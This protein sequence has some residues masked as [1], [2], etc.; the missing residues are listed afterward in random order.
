MRWSQLDVARDRALKATASAANKSLIAFLGV[1]RAQVFVMEIFVAFKLQDLGHTAWASL[2]LCFALLPGALLCISFVQK[3]RRQA[4][5]LAAL[6]LG[7][8]S[9]CWESW[10]IADFTKEFV[11][12]SD[13]STVF[14]SLP[15][16]MLQS[17]LM[18]HNHFIGQQCEEAFDKTC[19][20][21]C[22]LLPRKFGKYFTRFDCE[23]LPASGG[24]GTP[25]QKKIEPQECWEWYTYCIDACAATEYLR[26][27]QQAEDAFAKLLRNSGSWNMQDFLA[28]R[29]WRKKAKADFQEVME[30]DSNS[31][32][33]AGCD[34]QASTYEFLFPDVP[35]DTPVN[36]ARSMA[37]SLNFQV[38]L[39]YSQMLSLAS[40]A[41]SLAGT[42]TLRVVQADKRIC[43]GSRRE[44]VAEALGFYVHYLLDICSTAGSLT[45]FVCGTSS[46]MRSGMFLGIALISVVRFNQ[47]PAFKKLVWYKRAGC[48][49][50]HCVISPLARM[51]SAPDMD[52]ELG[53][54]L[55]KARV[56]AQ[57]LLAV[58]GFYGMTQQDPAGLAVWA[59]DTVICFAV[60]IA[61]LAATFIRGPAAIWSDQWDQMTLD[62]RIMK[63]VLR[64]DG[65]LVRRVW[66]RWALLPCSRQDSQA[67]VA[68][69]PGG[70]NRLLLQWQPSPP[71][72]HILAFMEE[73]DH[74][75]PGSDI[76]V[77][78]D[79]TA[80]EVEETQAAGKTGTAT[81]TVSDGAA[82]SSPEAIAAS[83]STPPVALVSTS[84]GLQSEG[85]G[86]PGLSA[87]VIDASAAAAG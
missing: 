42:L 63:F 76:E 87:D 69:I 62:R 7:F 71:D 41:L 28:N 54:H 34:A 68:G 86:L 9:A 31:W 11:V 13:V 36:A 74:A 53:C 1:F 73:Q 10:K 35:Q 3:G 48:A 72:D 77:D 51:P 30:E 49:V 26:Q 39:M 75:F 79:P 21:Q 23:L 5:L 64:T 14:D 18:L 80:G 66:R 60:A 22:L 8:H 70:G 83:L 56:A 67:P 33:A 12:A 29:R 32:V 44:W 38:L 50:A 27:K 15:Q 20:E 17:Y 55:L 25:T 57:G 59:T 4:A 81:G 58:L 85:E 61:A 82:I 46:A 47:S 45:F 6:G 65:R 16:F 37:Q 24:Q 52:A 40:S 84:P 78:D 2:V 43:G 19:T